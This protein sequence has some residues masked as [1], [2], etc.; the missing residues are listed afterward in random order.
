[1]RIPGF[2]LEVIY[3]NYK[4]FLDFFPAS[5][6]GCFRKT[7]CRGK[8]SHKRAKYG[9]GGRGLGDA[10]SLNGFFQFFVKEMHLPMI[11]VSPVK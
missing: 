3:W 6:S 10:S 7:L 11:T 4:T 9:V 2:D 1:M 8:R 5:S